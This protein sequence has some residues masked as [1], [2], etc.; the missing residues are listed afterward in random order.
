M[1]ELAVFIEVD[2]LWVFEIILPKLYIIFSVIF[3]CAYTSKLELGAIKPILKA[4]RAE[5][6]KSA[7][8]N[9]SY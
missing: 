7:L 9:C 5:F 4:Y 2:L 1:Q 8:S 6:S 3:K